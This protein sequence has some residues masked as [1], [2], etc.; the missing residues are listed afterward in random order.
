[1]RQRLQRGV[2]GTLRYLPP[3]VR[4][5]GQV[6]AAG[7]KVTIR[8]A[9][10]AALPVPVVDAA[11]AVDPFAAA[12]PGAIGAGARQLVLGADAT[13][14]LWPGRRYALIAPSGEAYVVRVWNFD[15]TKVDLL[16]TIPR[17]IG[18]GAQLKGAEL[19]FDLS[20]EQTDVPVAGDSSAPYRDGG[21]VGPK[22]PDPTLFRAEW[23]Y[24]VRGKAL[25]GDD[26]V[27]LHARLLKSTLEP[28][29]LAPYLPLE[30]SRLARVDDSA[31]FGGCM[32]AAWSEVLEDLELRGVKPDR[33]M[34]P[35]VLRLPHIYK[36]LWLMSSGWGEAWKEWRGEQAREYGARLGAAIESGT[37]IDAD[38]DAKQDAGEAWYGSSSIVR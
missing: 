14:G 11:A 29:E 32:A 25:R 26:L 23:S 22:R 9:D 5:L 34:D 35:N 16:N 1:M 30:A 33:V 19:A 8:R 7:P 36:L 4:E 15:A 17:P 3:E 31:Q 2:A 20:A 28:D 6:P 12:V 13:A 24:T 21:G 10:G 37:W 18:A 27:N 38:D